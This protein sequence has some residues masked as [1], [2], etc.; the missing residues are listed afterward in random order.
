MELFRTGRFR[1]SYTNIVERSISLA[2]ELALL[3]RGLW[4]PPPP[5]PPERLLRRGLV[6]PPAE[7]PRSCLWLSAISISSGLNQDKVVDASEPASDEPRREPCREPPPG[8]GWG[9]GWD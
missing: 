5:P 2:S 9:W 6:P 8:W 3:E 4:L 1:L 7:L